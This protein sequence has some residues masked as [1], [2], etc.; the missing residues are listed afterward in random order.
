MMTKLL[1]APWWAALFVTGLAQAAETVE[2]NDAWIREAPPGAAVLAAYL[3]IE[4]G[5]DAERTLV[6]ADSPDFGRIEI[7]ATRIK[8]G[9]ASM[10]PLK[11]LKIAAHGRQTLAPGGTHL[12]LMQ[13]RR[14]LRAGDRVKLTLGF[15]GGL[16][17][18]TE[19]TVRHD[20]HPADHSHHHH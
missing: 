18:A 8:G 2:V 6:A 16:R 13:P 10:A 19:A 14:E 11:G 17:V 7:H 9:M 20:E 5:G 3:T 1:L 12:M 4:N 15:D